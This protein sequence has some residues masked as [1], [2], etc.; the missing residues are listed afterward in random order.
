VAHTHPFKAWREPPPPS[1]LFPP[2]V[3]SPRAPPHPAPPPWCLSEPLG[4]P[5]IDSRLPVDRTPPATL[6]PPPH[7]RA[8]IMVSPLC[9]EATRCVPRTPAML[10]PP[11]P[12][13]L[14]ARV[15]VDSHTTM[16]TRACDD[17]NTEHVVR[18]GGRPS[19]HLHGR[20]ARPPWPLGRKRGSTLCADFSG[21]PFLLIF[22]KFFYNSKIHRKWIKARKIHS[23]FL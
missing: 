19:G 12:L 23:K 7:R 20:W 4:L 9:R 3:S 2:I 6:A 5:S 18:T 14:T 15:G 11:S 1:F 13:H 22:Q 10:E 16:A 17:H 8:T 21:F